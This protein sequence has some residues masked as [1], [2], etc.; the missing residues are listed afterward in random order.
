M[1]SVGFG[2][3]PLYVSAEIPRRCTTSRASLRA[4]LSSALRLPFTIRILL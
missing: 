3:I 2:D 4:P 1:L